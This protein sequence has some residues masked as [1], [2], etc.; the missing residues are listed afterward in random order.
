MM[1]CNRIARLFADHRYERLLEEVL[2][3]GREPG[4][5]IRLRLADAAGLSAAAVGFALQRACELHDAPGPLVT[6]LADALLDL[7]HDDG[8]FGTSIATAAAIAGLLSLLDQVSPAARVDLAWAAMVGIEALAER[9]EENAL[10]DGDPV[11]S[12]FVAWQLGH[13]SDFV[14]RIRYGEFVE[15]LMQA[16]VC[17][18]EPAA[19]LTGMARVALTTA[20]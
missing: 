11:T 17:A 7:Q 2:A 14:A 18:E 8:L 10:I 20:A 13:R 15:A 16:G 4:L 12:A 6:R 5:A 3:N 19:A 1:S 9:Q